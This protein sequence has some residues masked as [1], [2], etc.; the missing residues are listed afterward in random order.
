MAKGTI[1]GLCRGQ[2]GSSYR[3]WVEWESKVIHSENASLLSA[4]AFLQR[5]DGNKNSAYNLYLPRKNKYVSIDGEKTIS[6]NNGIDTRN[7][8]KVIIARVDNKK[9]LHDI[10]GTK[11]VAIEAFVQNINTTSLS[12]CKLSALVDLDIID[13]NFPY[14]TDVPT[15]SEITQ[16]SAKINFGYEN[17]E[18]IEFSIDN[19]KT[20]EDF[21]G[22]IKN[23]S[24]YKN[25]TIFIKLSNSETNSVVIS[26]P[27][28]FRTL[29][30]YV[31]S[32]VFEDDPIIINKG[33]HAKV[34]YSVYPENASIQNLMFSSND[35][36]IAAYL[37][38][39]FYGVNFGETT[40]NA[41]TTD[42]S[43]LS[44]TLN[45][46]VP[47]RVQSIESAYDF[48]TVKK[49][50]KALPL[51]NVVPA[52]AYNKKYFL[53]SSD[54]SVLSVNGTEIIA[55]K[56]GN[57]VITATTLDG[58]FT[59]ECM[60]NVVEGYSWYDFSSPPEILNAED[61]NHIFENIKTIRLLLAN[62]GISIEDI[63][64]V[65]A[66]KS[67]PVSKMLEI[68][69]NIEYNLDRISGNSYRSTYYITPVSVGD[70]ASDYNDIFRWINIINDMY[71]MLMGFAGKWSYVLLSDG[72]PLIEGKKIV[73]RG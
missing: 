2:A 32:V 21:Y 18:K 44:Y 31:E 10:D 22:E 68:L 56:N 30:I 13:Q 73:I 1:N 52:N 70:F 41:K 40:I 43:N 35:I 36:K 64:D 63:I 23:L 16:T 71:N 66:E 11:K 12:D 54:E 25:Y 17:T 49:G 46:V 60:V 72:F 53:E 5:S 19:Q 39:S 20:W 37:A 42:G 3:F 69:Q 62:N 55:L 38:K 7:L 27:V 59:A 65:S 26:E 45:V 24:P 15:V 4:T 58:N 34:K 14:F 50:E 29:P 61:I 47:V 33:E 8:Q 51:F 6:E 67:M 9:I 48:L 28:K 57:A